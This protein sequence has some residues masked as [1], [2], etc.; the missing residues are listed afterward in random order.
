M[1]TFRQSQSM[2]PQRPGV[3][4]PQAPTEDWTEFNCWVND[5]ENMV[6]ADKYWAQPGMEKKYPTLYRLYNIL[7]IIPAANA[8]VERVFS[9]SGRCL[10]P[11]NMSMTEDTI[12]TRMMATLYIKL[13]NDF[14]F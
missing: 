1:E 5:R 11:Y 7:R 14:G 8:G 6:D 4:L 3:S 12:E 2:S 13:Q 10:T 9:H